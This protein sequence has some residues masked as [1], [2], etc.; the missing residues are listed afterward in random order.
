MKSIIIISSIILFFTFQSCKAQNTDLNDDNIEILNLIIPKKDTICLFKESY[1]TGDRKSPKNLIAHYFRAYNSSKESAAY[2]LFY[3]DID[4]MI[5]IE[6]LNEMKNRYNS[7]SMFE[8]RKNII[9]D[10]NVRLISIK[11]NNSNCLKVYRISEPLYTTDKIKAIIRVYSS[12][13]KT[14]GTV[15]IVLKKENGKWKI[16]GGIPIGTS[17]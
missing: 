6:E 7:W 12:V 4:G 14:G 1:Y 2:K 5:T 17:G 13:N 3:E 8:W 15:L 16:K 11:N 10:K 9:Q